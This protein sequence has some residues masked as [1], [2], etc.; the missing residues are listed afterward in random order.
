ML[1]YLFGMLIL[2]AGGVLLLTFGCGNLDSSLQEVNIVG[3]ETFTETTHPMAGE[4]EIVFQAASFSWIAPPKG[5]AIIVEKKIGDQFQAMAN[6][7]IANLDT[8]TM[9]FTDSTLVLDDTAT[10]RLILL[11]QGRSSILKS[12][13]DEDYVTLSIAKSIR[14]NVPDTVIPEKG[15]V[16]LEWESLADTVTYEIELI[17]QG[18]QAADSMMIFKTINQRGVKPVRWRLDAEDLIP[19]ARYV[20]NVTAVLDEP[21]FVQIVKGS[22]EFFVGIEEEEEED[23]T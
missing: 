9:R 5:E 23:N 17:P 11:N 19:E 21:G 12:G 14:F 7:R 10:Y 22:R 2:A 18:A 4:S 1:K 13:K 6:L 15:K 20:I 8:D 3:V 16:L